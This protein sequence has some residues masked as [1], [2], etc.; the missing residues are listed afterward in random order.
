MVK[1]SIFSEVFLSKFLYDFKLSTVPNIR[2]IKDVVDSLIKE[3]ESGKL[4]SLKEEE[5][6]SRFVTSFF[7]DILS[8]NYGNAN[9][10]ML[11]EEKKSLTDGTKPDAVLGYF[12]ADKEK[13]EV[14]VVIEVKDA[15]T[16][17]DEKQ[18]RE[19]NISPVEQAFGYAHKTG[20][21]CNWVIVTNIN[22]IRFYSAQDSSCFQVYML[23][24][25]NDES[26]L[27]ELLFLFHKDRF[28]KHDLLEKSN[29]DKLF[30]LSKLKSK[31][32]GEYLHIIDKM[33]YSLKR[34]EEFGFVDPDYLASIKPFNILDEYVWHYHDFKLFTINPEI[35]N[36]L[37]QITINEQEISFS[38]SLK[39]ELKG[40]DVNEAIEKLK[41][42]F[43]FLNKCLI[44]EIHAVRDYELEVKPQKN[45]IKPPKTHIFSCKEDNIIKMNIDLL[46]TNIDCDCLICNYRNFDFDRFIRKLKQA[47]GNLDHNSIEHAFGNFL[48]SSNDYRTPYFILNEIRNT[49][50]STPEKSVTY[51]LATLNSTFLYNLIEMSEIDDTE[52]IRSHIRAID[53]DKLLYNELEFYI[54]REL[55]EYLKKVKDDDIIHKVQDNVE[56]LL[57]QVNKLKKLID[58]GGWQSGPNYAYNLLVNYEKCFKHHY[59][60]SIFYV[61]FDRY[62]KIS[63][64]ILQALLISYNTPGY[65]LVT[66]NDFILTESILHIP[67]SKLQEILSEQETIDVDNNSVE[68]LLSKLKNLLY[69]YV[70]T[71]FFN[72]FT[73][74]D[75]VTVQLENWDFA[76]LYTTIFTN[77]FTILSRINVTKE[78]FAPVVKPLIGFLDNEDKLAHYNLREF[79]NFVIKKGNL[80]DDY[81]LESILNIAIRRDKMYNNKYE[82]IIRNIPKAFLKHKPQYQ[83]S[84]RNLVSKLLLNCEREDGTFKN[85]RN[86]INLAK[87]ANEPCRQILR[88]AF[89]DFLDNEFDD[90]FYALLLHAGI[91]RFDEGVY[92]EKYLSQINAEVN[93]RTFKLGNVK[94]ISTSFIN[95]IL[96]KSKLKIDAE[97]ECFDK[98]EDL[99]AF[100]S[101]LLNP[102]K[103][104]YRFFDSDW[105]I[106]LSEY[107]TFLERLANI[108]DIATAAEERLEREYNASLAEIKYRYL[109]SSS[110]TTKEN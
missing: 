18:K 44:T 58:D 4:S 82:G 77:I 88:K 14:R 39:E 61:K 80:F 109:M 35:Y 106:V 29:T 55:L 60:N 32:E 19:K 52:E 1:K 49:T 54:E 75:I 62:K 13:D 102:K 5:I 105:L 15:N 34:F 40:F 92:F 11:R 47:E 41:W 98:L 84:N 74:N 28:I 65:G 17:L 59:N 104:D 64:L 51:F 30:E 79:E 71:G 91:L 68:K 48:V 2:R 25:L 93:H 8:F 101:W 95:F 10:W 46:S 23:K 22:E 21:N 107:P 63:R 50:K 45:V 43:K 90:E 53:L 96:L 108:D 97:L 24:E 85:Y 73:K 86:T 12:Y 72:D 78:Q 57:E 103:F 27:K 110:Q 99:N 56:S 3:L 7:G 94:P 100:E 87:I 89:T 83:Y 38:D 67:S 33:Y 66:F 36:L 37:T 70:Q 20:G 6:K 26:K 69:S 31:T 16:K 81:D 9:A 42:S 76:Q